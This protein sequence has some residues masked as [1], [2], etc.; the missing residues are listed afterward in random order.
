MVGQMFTKLF[1]DFIS[2]NYFQDSLAKNGQENQTKVIIILLLLSFVWFVLGSTCFRFF[3]TYL[4]P[5]SLYLYSTNI[6]G[7]YFP[8]QTSVSLN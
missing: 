1:L 4:A 6:S 2:R 7:E 8:V 5:S 3:R